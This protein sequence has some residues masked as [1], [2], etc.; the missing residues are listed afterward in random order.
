MCLFVSCQPE[1]AVL[2]STVIHR[3]VHILL[4]LLLPPL[5]LDPQWLTSKHDEPSSAS[6]NMNNELVSASKPQIVC[7][8]TLW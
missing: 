8:F 6:Q 4:L 3:M 5:A 2:G 1:I 7:V